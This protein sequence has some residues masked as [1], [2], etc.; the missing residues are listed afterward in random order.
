MARILLKGYVLFIHSDYMDT[1]K[2]YILSKMRLCLN[3]S[4]TLPILPKFPNLQAKGMDQGFSLFK[5]GLVFILGN[6][7][8]TVQENLHSVWDIFNLAL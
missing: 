6:S 7:S 3:T 5:V 8:K 4:V 2:H 1:K